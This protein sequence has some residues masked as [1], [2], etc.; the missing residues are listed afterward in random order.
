MERLKMQTVTLFR[1][2]GAAEY[3]LIAD[4]AWRAFPPRLREQPIFYPVATET[5][6]IEIARDWN[7]KEPASVGYVTA[8]EVDA[9]FIARYPLQQAGSR[10]HLEY[11][12]PAEDLAEFNARIVGPIRIIHEFRAD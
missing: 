12:I 5:Y 3:R 9:E 1:P 2:I 4:S 10:T 8:F 7:T 11:W 6:A